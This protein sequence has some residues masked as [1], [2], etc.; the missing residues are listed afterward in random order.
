[1]NND[2]LID[3]LEEL[4]IQKMDSLHSISHNNA[5]EYCMAAIRAHFAS[6]V[7][8]K[9][10][11]EATSTA[12]AATNL[13]VYGNAGGQNTA[14]PDVVG[15]C[16]KLL[17]SLRLRYPMSIDEMRLSKEIRAMAAMGLQT[18]TNRYKPLQIDTD[19]VELQRHI[20]NTRL[21]SITNGKI[22]ID[23]EITA[24]VIIGI[25]GG[26]AD[27]RHSSDGMRQSN[28]DNVPPPASDMHCK[29]WMPWTHVCKECDDYM[30]DASTRKDEVSE[31]D[32]AVSKPSPAN[33]DYSG[34]GSVGGPSEISVIEQDL[35]KCPGC[36]GPADNGHDRCLPP[37]PYCCTKCEET[38][39]KARA[40][41][42]TATKPVSG[43]LEV[44]EIVPHG[45]HTDDPW[46]LVTSEGYLREKHVEK[47]YVKKRDYVD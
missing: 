18:S 44:T 38:D 29:H 7:T 1:M 15:K 46:Q 9:E 13:A 27:P 24:K 11:C 19:V 40:K 37:S 43:L 2:S 21:S 23:P 36:G 8:V 35:S 22:V 3:K 42:A 41:E 10:Y 28:D 20:T 39:R 5:I 17:D 30:G 14:A 25:M 4:K 12:T 45:G 33:K 6:P 47:I 26:V 34:F 31:A 16:I 32:R